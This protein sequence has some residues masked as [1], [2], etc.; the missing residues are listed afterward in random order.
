MKSLAVVLLLWSQSMS[1]ADDWTPP[2]NPDPSRILDEAQ[3]D[4]RNGRNKAALAKHIWFHNNALKHNRALY[5]V[6]LSFALSY[7]GNLGKKYPPALTE[8]RKIRDKAAE[9]VLK[10]NTPRESFRDF[11][12]INEQLRENG[13]TAELFSQLDRKK[14]KV[15][16]TVYFIA[17]PALIDA[18]QYKLCAR[19]VD[20]KKDLETMIKTYRAGLE[21]SKIPKLGKRHLEIVNRLFTRDAATLVALLAVT[22]MKDAAEQIANSAK[23]VRDDM[24]FHRVLDEA[25]KGTFPKPFP[26]TP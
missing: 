18:K 24:A 10:G 5:G 20:P 12:A 14:P 9:S 22:D 4:A 21:R 13:E 6:R 26:G 17:Q 23:K 25:V 16:K 19:Y 15:A 1:I 7:W 3:D 11:A 2:K 8:L